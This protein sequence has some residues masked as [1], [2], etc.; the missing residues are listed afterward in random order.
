M[1]MTLLVCWSFLG[2]G[3]RE[4][5]RVEN[6]LDGRTDTWTRQIVK[7]TIIGRKAKH[8]DFRQLRASGRILIAAHTELWLSWGIVDGDLGLDRSNQT[9]HTLANA[10]FGLDM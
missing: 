4:A 3:F 8:V 6:P 7:V 2:E 5:Y 1:A 9:K 10:V